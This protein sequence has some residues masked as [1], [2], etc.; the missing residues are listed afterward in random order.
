MFQIKQ[1]KDG[2]RKWRFM[3]TIC[4]YQDSR[5]RDSLAWIREML[6]AGYSSDRKDGITELRINGFLQIKN[7]LGDLLPFIRFKRKQ[8]KALHSVVSLLSDKKFSLLSEKEILDLVDLIIVIQD[9][10]Y[11]NSHRKTRDELLKIIGLT[12]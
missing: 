4:F 10:N 9:Y 5:H 3:C 2:K 11:S 12:P 6:G 1:R 7:I 8:A